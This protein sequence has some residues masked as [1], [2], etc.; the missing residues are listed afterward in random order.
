[1][2]TPVTPDYPSMAMALSIE[3]PAFIDGRLREAV[4]R[5]TFSTENPATWCPLAQVAECRG[6]DVN[7]AIA[8]GRRASEK[9]T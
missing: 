1:M 7:F 8:A 5:R 3:T 9:G 4:G 6:E 2:T